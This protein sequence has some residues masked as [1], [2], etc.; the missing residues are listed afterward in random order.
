MEL[1]ESH[2]LALETKNIN[3]NNPVFNIGLGKGTSILELIRQ[4]EEVNNV[5]V[6]YKY[7]MR[8]QGDISEVYCISTKA[9]NRLKFKPKYT[10]KDMCRDAWNYKLKSSD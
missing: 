10:I 5:R 8:R 1:A 9:K 4:F 2:I 3:T 6:P 7:M